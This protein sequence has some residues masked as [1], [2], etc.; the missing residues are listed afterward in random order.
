[1]SG[2]PH[3]ALDVRSK[4]TK[5]STRR[6]FIQTYIY[7]DLEKC[8]FHYEI[9]EIASESLCVTATDGKG[10]LQVNEDRFV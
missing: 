7:D 3:L 6:I 4:K 8:C 2:S 10:R 9:V 1:M 5:P